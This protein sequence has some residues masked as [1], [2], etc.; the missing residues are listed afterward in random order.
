MGS[1]NLG[2]EQAARV[3]ELHP[4]SISD[5]QVRQE[6]YPYLSVY[7]C[8]SLLFLSVP[9]S[10]RQSMDSNR[11]QA[12]ASLSRLI[13]RPGRGAECSGPLVPWN[14]SSPVSSYSPGGN[15]GTPSIFLGA[16]A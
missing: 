10:G 8:F 9:F 1:N 14:S 16:G 7:S 4:A 6:A 5:Q 11:G 15:S 13:L 2:A 3:S 12:I